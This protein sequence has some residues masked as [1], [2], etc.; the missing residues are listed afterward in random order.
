MS[1]D[2]EAPRPSDEDASLDP[3][4]GV[5]LKYGALGGKTHT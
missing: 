3:P 1:V 5:E 2:D 4:P